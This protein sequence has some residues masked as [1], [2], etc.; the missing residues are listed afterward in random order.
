MLVEQK[1]IVIHKDAFVDISVEDLCAFVGNHLLLCCDTLL[2][3]CATTAKAAFSDK[4]VF[5]NLDE[6]PDE[7]LCQWQ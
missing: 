5:S 3:E 6:V 7:Y 4:D 2:Y 1:Q